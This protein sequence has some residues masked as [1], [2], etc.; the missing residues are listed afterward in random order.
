LDELAKRLGLPSRSRLANIALQFFFEL[1]EED[2]P[3]L[4]QRRRVKIL[5]DPSIKEK[6]DELSTRLLIRKAELINIALNE[7]THRNRVTSVQQ[8]HEP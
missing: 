3:V 2:L 7:F 1:N 6:L 4:G 8:D 5:L